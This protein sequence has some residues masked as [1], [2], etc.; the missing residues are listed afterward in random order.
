MRPEEESS[1][2]ASGAKRG[3]LVVREGLVLPESELEVR[4]TRSSGPGGQ[5]VNK[6][7][8]RIELRFDVAG[9]SVLSEEEKQRVRTRLAN[10]TS[11]LGVLRVVSQR[12]R[13]QARNETQARRRLVELLVEALAVP[14][15]RR[16]TRVG[17]GARERRLQS[18]RRRSDAKRDRR[19]PADSD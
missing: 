4:A 9:S 15:R 19:A 13:S 14:K 7:S 18:K 3:G 1:G 11:R 8:T 10:R 2:S 6:V 12:E 16:P 17:A 5:N